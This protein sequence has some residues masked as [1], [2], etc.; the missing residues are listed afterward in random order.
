MRKKKIVFQSDF[1][2]A[3]TG[4]GRNTRAILTYLYST[5]K[6]ELVNYA[7]GIQWASSGLEI[8]PWKSVGAVPNN[9]A[10]INE[11]N[12]DQGQTRL[13]SYGAYCLDDVIKQEKPDV[14]IAVQD[15]WGIDFAIPRPWFNKINSALWTT[16][17]SLPILPTAI[18]AASKTKNFWV[19]SNFA[20]KALHQL[21][22]THTKTL[23]GCIDTKHFYR[24][25]QAQKAEL[26]AKSGIDKE[27][28]IV[29]FVFRNQLRKSVPNLLEGYS[30]FKKENP[31]TK[32][33]LLLHT[34]FSEGWNILKLAKQYGVDQ[35][36]I[37]TTFI[38][39]N[40]KNYYVGSFSKQDV[41]CP[42]CKA[43][44]SCLT[45]SV[46]L[47]VTEAQLNEVYNLMDVYCHPFTSGGQEI[48]IQ[49]AKLAGLITLVTNYSCGEEMCEHE[50][51]SLPLE[52]AK[53]T[54]QD[55]EFIK[56]STRPISISRQL[57]KVLNM[58]LESRREMGNK[59][60][61]WIV[62]NFSVESVGRKLEEFIDHS[63]FINY[64]DSFFFNCSEKN[65]NPEA[66]IEVIKDDAEW[67]NSLYAKILGREA[68]KDGF[69]YWTS[70]LAKGM[71]RVDI[72]KYFRETALK[73]KNE[74]VDKSDSSLESQL[75]K[76][77]DSNDEG[78]RILYVMPE[79]IGD[80]FL[81]TSLFKNIKEAYPGH[82]L[83]VAI[84][85]EYFDILV[86]NP[87]V[88]KAISYVPQMDNLLWLEGKGDHKGF[89][90]IAFLPHLGTQRMLNYVHNGK[91]NIALDIKSF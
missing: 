58:S 57:S 51:Y 25:T 22:H 69:S 68:D 71:A 86:C 75:L 15:I 66:V 21:G 54:E 2:L 78:K 13:A 40:C 74:K 60:R 1:S 47:G 27:D 48:P 52:W 16:L 30:L 26:R 9:Q 62:K 37:L 43:K 77:L 29:G 70:S 11:I 24:K 76:L 20:E 36:E 50:A 38:C 14:Y 8:T 63:P 81:S 31:K 83:Y 39:K 10:L 90:E 61:E 80:I 41:D 46:A 85:N 7:C 79:S 42:N 28:F 82:N 5:G 59:A 88:F 84:K 73:T 65:C 44:G 45:T 35:A 87:H 91:T 23:H 67:V 4:F 32:S 56:A 12:K 49:E 55:T 18:D 17:D 53:Y 34:N 64:D 3:K 89:F 33:K 72:E 6:Y 19:W